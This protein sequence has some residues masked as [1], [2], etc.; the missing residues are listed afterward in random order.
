MLSRHYCPR[1]DVALEV[2]LDGGPILYQCA[3]GHSI[4]AADLDLEY[5][6]RN[7]VIQPALFEA[8]TN[9][10]ALFEVGAR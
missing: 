10:P 6:P 5:V 4:Y 3:Q 1:H 2:T 7:P 8:P 9:Q